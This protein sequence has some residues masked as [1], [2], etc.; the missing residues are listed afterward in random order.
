MI[1]TLIPLLTGMLSSG[2]AAGGTAAATGGAASG[3]ELSSILGGGE[4]GSFAKAPMGGGAGEAAIPGMPGRGQ[5][6]QAGQ[7]GQGAAP[8][9]PSMAPV[10]QKIMQDAYERGMSAQNLLTQI[11]SKDT[12]VDKLLRQRMAS[13]TR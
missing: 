11:T 9:G 1:E 7:K 10:V 6:G 8:A 13:R 5:V 4:M 12:I 2:T 3:G